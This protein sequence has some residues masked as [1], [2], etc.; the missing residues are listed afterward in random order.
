MHASTKCH[1]SSLS[2]LSS[3]IAF[4]GSCAIVLALAPAPRDVRAGSLIS[5]QDAAPLGLER[6]WFAQARV[7]VSRHRVT[8]WVLYENNLLA[9]TNGGLV[10]SFNAETGETLWTTQAGP[11]DQPAFGPAVSQDYVALVSGAS[12]YTLDR[13]S[14]RLL[15][16]TSLGS[17]P[18]EA[19]ALSNTDAYV[20]F[21]SGRIESYQLAD[22]KKPTW[23]FQSVGRIFYPPSVS[24]ELVT[25]PTSRGYLYV[26]QAGAPHVLYRIQTNSVAIAPPTEAFGLLFVAVQDGNVHC[27]KLLNGNEKWRYSMGFP[28]TGRPGVVGERLYVASSE[29]M[30]HALEAVSGQEL[31]DVPGITH[32]AA[33]GIKNV[34]GLDE[35]GRLVVINKETGQYIGTLPGPGRFKAVF[36]D[37]SDRIYLVDDR[38][39]VQCL[40]EMG[41][42]EPTIHRRVEAAAEKPSEEAVPAEAEMP[43]TDEQLDDSGFGAPEASP[44]SAEPSDDSDNP[45]GFE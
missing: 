14:G 38:G 23:Y 28:A 33:Q 15:W 31:W 30:L 1:K 9:A 41:A 16:S 4:L 22:P 19:P 45:F 35:G 27:F 10:Q 12:L 8:N 34:Y 7:D 40:R 2:F 42:V 13:A 5:Y 21:L 43:A 3:R 20:P 24:G 29:P 32:F 37:Y 25:W 11:L 39:L 26:G 6:V 18:A 36:N 44:F 17:A